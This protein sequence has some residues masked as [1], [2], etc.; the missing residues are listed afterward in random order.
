MVKLEAARQLYDKIEEKPSSSQ[1]K[2][3]I[4]NFQWGVEL[5]FG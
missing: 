4:L 3:A 5:V 1:K 2:A